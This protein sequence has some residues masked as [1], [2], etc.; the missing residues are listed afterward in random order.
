MQTRIDAIER[1]LSPDQIG[2]TA[3]ASGFAIAL[4]ALRLALGRVLRRFLLP[5]QP[6]P[7]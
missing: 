2:S 3:S 5:Y 6:N 4:R 1:G 7:R